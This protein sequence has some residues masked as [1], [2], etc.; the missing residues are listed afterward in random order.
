MQRKKGLDK[1]SCET[2]VIRMPRTPASRKKRRSSLA[3]RFALS[4]C[5]FLLV[6]LILGVAL[7]GT[8]AQNAR[9]NFWQQE[10]TQLEANAASMGN[11]FSLMN[12]Y[13]RHL[14]TDST[15]I[16]FSNMT[17]LSEKNYVYTAYEIMQDLSSKLFS[18]M[19]LPVLE[20]PIYL[21]ASGYVISASQFTP[22]EQYYASYRYYKKEKYQDWLAAL[23]SAE[24]PGRF[25]SVTDF[26]GGSS[27]V[28]FA[29]DINSLSSRKVPAVVWFELNTSALRTLF[30]MDDN[31]GSRVLIQDK[32]GRRQLLLADDRVIA[33]LPSEDAAL[34]QEDEALLQAMT[35]AAYDASGSAVYEDMR[36]FR[37]EDRNGWVYYAA[38]PTAMCTAA[39]GNFDLPFLAICALGLL[40]GLALV[41]LLVRQNMRPV[42]QLSD[43]L[44]QAEGDRARLQREMEEQRPLLCASYLRK[45]LSG[46]VSS[47]EE[48]SYMMKFL[49]LEPPLKYYVLYCIAN[50]QDSVLGDPLEEYDT[51]STHIAQFLSGNHPLY[52]YTTPSRCFVVLAAYDTAVEDPL[53]DL[54][55][56][57][58]RLH[59][60]LSTEH[61]LWFYA[62]VGK[63]TQSPQL[64][65]ESYEQARQAAR[66]TT[67]HHIFIPYEMIRKDADS[68]YY[69][70]ELSA[71]LQHFITTGNKQQVVELL[72]MIRQENVEERSLSVKLLNF[73][74]SD[75][76]NTLLK[77]RFQITAPQDEAGRARLE[78]LDQR[79]SEQATFPLLENCATLL[80][81]FFSSSAT[82]SDP[83]PEVE[84]Y[85]MENFT[86]PSL[87]LTKLSD[88]FNISESYLS[89]LFKDRT[90]QNFSVY[91]ENLRL[92]EAVRRLKQGNCNLT[93]LAAELGYNNP[94]TFRRAFKKRYGMTPSEMK[95]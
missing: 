43:Q 61:G 79:L 68:W 16:R 72:A 85:L 2:S 17:G 42:R 73:L 38:L 56:R 95:G 21:P 44:V 82:P 88:R 5:G 48:F 76:R 8:S 86:D 26:G 45:V 58:V 71:K 50:R 4:Y 14:L 64:L 81:E 90:G 51:L 9:E 77:A 1:F 23:E 24:T 28:C 52:F 41:L 92:N 25:F 54:Q 19:N 20:S 35:G 83:I 59:E 7:Y 13:A 67:K 33:F 75:L 57:V 66:Y 15:F 32:S 74:L 18:L 53:M 27:I 40:G 62:G 84:R 80:C 39:L 60:D 69:P 49:N 22:V 12:G 11:H 29:L 37:R 3:S 93:E 89:H 87:C 91:L 36:L 65:W 70:I 30:E 78:V 47:N 46:H 6:C 63:G 34:S 55:S 31:P 94:T 10:A